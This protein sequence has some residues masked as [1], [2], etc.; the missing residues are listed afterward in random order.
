MQPRLFLSFLA[1]ALPD[2]KSLPKQLG[3]LMGW[4]ESS[5]YLKQLALK[6]TTLIFFSPTFATRTT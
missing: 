6:V 5:S 2:K 1:F 3:L 4:K